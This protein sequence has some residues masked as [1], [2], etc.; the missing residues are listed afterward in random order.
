MISAAP[1]PGALAPGSFWLRRIVGFAFLEYDNKGHR[2]Q[3]PGDENIRVE[4]ME[5]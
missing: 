1:V 2:E 3:N 4:A 5:G